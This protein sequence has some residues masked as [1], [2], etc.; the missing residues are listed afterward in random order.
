MTQVNGFDYNHEILYFSLHMVSDTNFLSAFWEQGYMLSTIAFYI[1]SKNSYIW[2]V[3]FRKL[4]P[5]CAIKMP[6]LWTDCRTGHIELWR[7][8]RMQTINNTT[9][10]KYR[11]EFQRSVFNSCLSVVWW[12]DLYAL[13]HT[14]DLNMFYSLKSMSK[15]CKGSKSSYVISS[16]DGHL[17]KEL[18]FKYDTGHIVYIHD[19]G[20]QWHE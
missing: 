11:W 15:H 10:L 6:I 8:S 20:M 2:L 1:G 5:K 3:L 13:L 12:D 9:A 4:C 7:W 16:V 14:A 18:N 19:L 17:P